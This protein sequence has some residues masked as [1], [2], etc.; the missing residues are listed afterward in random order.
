V[1]GQ[2]LQNAAEEA[3]KREESIE[4]SAGEFCFA[5]IF[6][7]GRGFADTGGLLTTN[8]VTTPLQQHRNW[9]N[10]ILHEQWKVAGNK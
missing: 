6:C 10:I 7:A 2:E 8:S 9:L 4:G 3:A 5:L 1:Y